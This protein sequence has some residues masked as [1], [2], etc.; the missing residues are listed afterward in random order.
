MA[1]A[2]DGDDHC[3]GSGGVYG[4]VHGGRGGGRYTHS[5]SGDHRIS[6]VCLLYGKVLFCL[7]SRSFPH[8]TRV[9]RAH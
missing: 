9:I 4:G 1:A 2:G 3:S 5:G 7:C 6:Y 8:R